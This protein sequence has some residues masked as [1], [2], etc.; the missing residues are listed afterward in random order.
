MA[1]LRRCCCSA[2]A[3]LLAP[4]SSLDHGDPERGG[5]PR[6]ATGRGKCAPR[7]CAGASAARPTPRS[8]LEWGQGTRGLG[9]PG[10]PVPVGSAARGLRPGAPVRRTRGRLRRGARGWSCGPPGR[11]A[12]RHGGSPT[13]RTLLGA[14][15]RPFAFADVLAALWV[16]AASRES[17]GVGAGARGRFT[18]NSWRRTLLP[19]SPGREGAWDGAPWGGS[20]GDVR[21]RL[22]R[23]GVNGGLWLGR[24]RAG[25]PNPPAA[26]SPDPARPRRG[27]WSCRRRGALPG[28]GRRSLPATRPG[29]GWSRARAW[30][31]PCSPWGSPVETRR[32]L[33][34]RGGCVACPSGPRAKVP[35]TPTPGTERPVRRVAEA[36]RREGAGAV[37]AGRTSVRLTGRRADRV[38]AAGCSASAP[39]APLSPAAF[40]PFLGADAWGLGVEGAGGPA[41]DPWVLKRPSRQPAAWV[42]LWL[43]RVP[44]LEPDREGSLCRPAR[45]VSWPVVVLEAPRRVAERSL[46]GERSEGT[47]DCGGSALG[48]CCGCSWVLAQVSHRAGGLGAA[49]WGAFPPGLARGCSGTR[50]PCGACRAPALVGLGCR[51]LGR[52]SAEASDRKGRGPGSLR[53]GFGPQTTAWGA[54]RWGRSWPFSVWL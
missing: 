31:S 25:G 40:P 30:A 10:Q 7:N 48:G 42:V 32:P 1:A 5:G 44:A 41:R 13:E 23:P 49:R 8:R 28:A 24:R 27:G 47:E 22:R 35:A 4:C 17:V 21:R 52:D 34:V 33:R 54:G 26:P 20:C 12:D 37:D 16:G 38:P 2:R 51:R 53:R 45:W 46:R 50:G 39:G 43:V 11:L 15:R 29:W 14:P 19:K 36:A 3:P 6:A 9:A 18:L